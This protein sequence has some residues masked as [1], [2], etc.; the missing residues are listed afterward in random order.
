MSYQRPQVED[1]PETCIVPHNL[2]ESNEHEGAYRE[3]AGMNEEAPIEG[4]AWSASPQDRDEFRVWPPSP[5]DPGPQRRVRFQ[6]E[7]LKLQQVDED[8]VQR[9]REVIYDLQDQFGA[10]EESRDH[11]RRHELVVNTA[12]DNLLHSHRVLEADLTTTEENCEQICQLR[13]AMIRLFITFLRAVIF[14][15]M[16][17]LGGTFLWWVTTWE[18]LVL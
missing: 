10:L 13:P 18:T 16:V 15:H 4:P 8:Q 7:S 12:I 5:Q 2:D 11:Y 3:L 6:D 1:V 9:L 17:P 14:M